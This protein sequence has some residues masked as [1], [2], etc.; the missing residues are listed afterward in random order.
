MVV[1]AK[2]GNF[3][4]DYTYRNID[5]KKLESE[6]IVLPSYIAE[7]EPSL[8]DVTS[9]ATVMDIM[10]KGKLVKL[11]N[12]PHILLKLYL[13]IPFSNATAERSFSALRRVKIYFRNR[14][15]QEHL[16]HYLILNAHKYLTDVIDLENVLKHFVMVNE[17]R[18]KFFG[19]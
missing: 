15:T 6:L 2:H 1:A 7:T 11:F 3:T 13:K 8:R 9:I 19:M 16:N 12:E 17:R 18:M 5:I 4:I 14:L 10:K